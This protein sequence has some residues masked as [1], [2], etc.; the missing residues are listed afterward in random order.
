MEAIE[1][2][3][4][5]L[6]QNLTVQLYHVR[7]REGKGPAAAKL[8]LS[9]N[10]FTYNIS[11]NENLL[12]ETLTF[13]VVSQCPFTTR[14]TFGIDLILTAAKWNAFLGHIMQDVSSVAALNVSNLDSE[15]FPTMLKPWKI[16][17]YLVVSL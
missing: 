7:A 15:M 14:L 9:H 3:S 4:A 2:L 16:V 12:T 6:T 10:S 17:F 5:Y 11:T 1:T 13:S 8:Q